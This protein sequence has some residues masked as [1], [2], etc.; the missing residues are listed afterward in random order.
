MF[1]RCGCP[2]SCW[3]HRC[4]RRGGFTIVE[5]LVTIG[6][7]SILMS[8][9]LPAVQSARESARRSACQNNLRQLALA[10]LNHESTYGRLPSNGWGYGWVGEPGR[11]TDRDQPGGW[12]YNILDHVE[13]APLREIGKGEPE[14]LR[15]QS[16]AR[17]IVTPLPLF[18]CPSRPAPTLGPVGIISTPVNA[19][20]VL[21]VA[22]TDY[23][24]C[25]GDFITNTRS[26][27]AT[28]DDAQTYP[29]WRNPALATGVCFQRSRVKLAAITDGLSNTYLLGEKY[30]SHGGYATSDDDGY[31]QSLYSGVD[32]DLNRWTIDTPLPD[33][34]Y[35]DVRTFGSAHPAACHMALCDG[36]VRPV[37]YLVDGETHRRLGN[38]H[39]GN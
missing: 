28:L 35:I 33:S 17:L 26:G 29:D 27:P 38:R 12:A 6:I 7:I 31:D 32:L 1:G 39:D 4:C 34:E 16:L 10:M 18:R 25:E 36:S 2:R 9:I 5:L 23:A 20:Y 21:D 37:S 13:Q 14:A 15:R 19:D 22:K 8:L 3:P 30:V 11:G 24:C